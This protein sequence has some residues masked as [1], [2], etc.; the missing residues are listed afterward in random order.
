MSLRSIPGSVVA[1]GFVSL[2]MDVSSEMI[3]SLLP[4]FLVSVIGASALSVGLLEGMAEATASITKIFSGVIS[5][6]VGR[7]KPLLLLGYGMAALTKPVFPLAGTLA[8]VLAARFLDRVGKGIRGAPRDALVAEVTP[9]DLR[10]AAFGLRQSMDTV[11]AFA[12][13]ALAM[14]LMVLSGDDFRLVFWVAVIPAFIAVAIIVFAVRE[15]R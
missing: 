9:P 7:R 13:P 6:W 5:D 2:F 8:A 11:G 15:E 12:G 10:G 4:V 14:L 1:L 3:H